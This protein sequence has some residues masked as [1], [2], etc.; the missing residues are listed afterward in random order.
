MTESGFGAIPE[1]ARTILQ[2]LDQAGHEAYIVGGCVRDC[3]LGKRPAD[4]DITT[5]ATPQEVKQVF[6]HTVDTG[7]QHGTVTVLRRENGKLNGYEVTTYRIDGIYEDARHPKQVSFTKELAE[8]LR[9]RDFTVNAMAYHPEKGLV[10]LF[11]GQED[12]E[13][14]IIR[15]VGDATERFSEDALRMMRAIR[16]AA[17]LQGTIETDT[18]EALCRLHE[19]IAH[20]S[21]ERIRVEMEKLLVSDRPGDF[22]LF[23]ESGL[24]KHFLPEWDRMMETKQ[25]TPHH[26]YNVGEHTIH[27]MEALDVK[28]LGEA[29]PEEAYKT[30]LKDLRLALLLHDV[31]KPDCK[32]MD[33]DGV[34]HFAGH[35]GIGAKK[36]GE[37]LRR[38]KYDNDTIDTV[39]TLI[40]VHDSR[41]DPSKRSM[42]R[43]VSKTGER[44][45]PLIFF[46]L[47]ADVMGQSD[48]HRQDKLA[49]IDAQEACYREI[50]AAKDCLTLKELAVS[51]KDLIAAGMKPGPGIGEVLDRMLED[52]L[53]APE[54]NVKEYLLENYLKR[55]ET[56]TEQG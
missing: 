4:W 12:L 53:A 28:A 36:A 25:E 39:T 32:T 19:N 55:Q 50:I 49:L 26:C 1:G 48:Y 42:R 23:Y 52:V 11:H 51:G 41:W 10:D 17:Q 16:F 40:R 30:A 18:W 21:A 5:S 44:Y 3:L 2:K 22:R 33:D 37:I 35:P 45:F 34:A 38:L 56:V 7:L 29:C 27:A 24:T 6:G 20:V 15:A 47:R 54:H 43:A 46:L 13:K 8:D 9:R 31:A 14:R